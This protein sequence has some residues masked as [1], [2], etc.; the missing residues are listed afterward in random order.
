[1]V[2]YFSL[3]GTLITPKSQR[4][5]V[6]D[7]FC[8]SFSFFLP[9]VHLTVRRDEIIAHGRDGSESVYEFVELVY[10]ITL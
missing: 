7:T 5:C 1:M 3:G 10:L 8:L 9:L 4:C 6:T 2:P